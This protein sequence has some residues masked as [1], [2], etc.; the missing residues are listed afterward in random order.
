MTGAQ[1]LF[2]LASISG[3]VAAGFWVQVATASDATGVTAARR[4]RQSLQFAA[5]ATAIAFALA[6]AA[7]LLSVLLG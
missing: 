5:T 6:S 2:V 1:L 7:V 4:Q 3:L